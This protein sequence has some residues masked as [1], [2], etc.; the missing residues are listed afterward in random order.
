MTSIWGI[1][2]GAQPFNIVTF[3][4]TS[5]IP[6]TY[7]FGSDPVCDYCFKMGFEHLDGLSSIS[8]DFKF[9]KDGD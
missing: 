6:E 2:I 9:G 5:D 1:F 4:G 8:F 7:C 3:K